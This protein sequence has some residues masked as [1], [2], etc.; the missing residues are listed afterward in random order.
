MARGVLF[1]NFVGKISLRNRRL[2]NFKPDLV[3]FSRP[4]RYTVGINHRRDNQ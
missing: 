3:V 4:G 1:P 2:R